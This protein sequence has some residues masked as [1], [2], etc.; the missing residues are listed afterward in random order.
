[1]KGFKLFFPIAVLIL[2][3]LVAGTAFAASSSGRKA[4]KA[5]AQQRSAA[6]P[7]RA[8]VAPQL[9][10]VGEFGEVPAGVISQATKAS[11][12][13]ADRDAFG[14]APYAS[15]QARVP[16]PLTMPSGPVAVSSFSGDFT[17]GVGKTFSTINAAIATLNF[18][19]PVTGPTRFLLTDA[20]YSEAGFVLGTVAYGVGGPFPITF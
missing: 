7:Q 9:S 15:K 17:V 16:V 10:P 11:N 20:S 19:A 12:E 3:G 4:Q 6:A 13:S 8:A 14:S 2:V 18:G 5:V 1:M